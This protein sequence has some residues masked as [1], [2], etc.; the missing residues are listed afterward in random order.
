MHF[1]QDIWS[2][3]REYDKPL[4]GNSKSSCIVLAFI[5]SSSYS[6]AV[7]FEAGKELLTFYL[8]GLPLFTV[9]SFNPTHFIF[10]V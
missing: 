9:L 8:A 1:F 5:I 3:V 7:E 2:T 6:F 10:T 4:T